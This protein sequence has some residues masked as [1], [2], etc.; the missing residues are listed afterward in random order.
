MLFVNTCLFE[1]KVA[2]CRLRASLVETKGADWKINFWN[3]IFASCT[4]LYFFS[5][6]C[7]CSSSCNIFLKNNA[8]HGAKLGQ[9]TFWSGPYSRIRNKLKGTRNAIRVWGKPPDQMTVTWAMT[10]LECPGFRGQSHASSKTEW[11][12][13]PAWLF[14]TRLRWRIW[15]SLLFCG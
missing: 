13:L 15:Q 8:G 3:L 10:N 12:V 6:Y 14:V 1:V 5:K 2:I 11:P 7:R 9:P 4:H